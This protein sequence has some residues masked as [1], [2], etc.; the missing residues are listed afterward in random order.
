MEKQR[1]VW[2]NLGYALAATPMVYAGG[3]V[4]ST[5][6]GALDDAIFKLQYGGY[7]WVVLIGAY[8]ISFIYFSY[9]EEIRIKRKRKNTIS[10]MILYW[11]EQLAKKGKAPPLTSEINY[12]SEMFMERIIESGMFDA[13]IWEINYPNGK[14][15]D[16]IFDIV[17]NFMVFY[18]AQKKKGGVV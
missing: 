17:N 2:K 12:A 4:I 15:S 3:L 11:K 16:Y 10:A 7:W 6:V 9:E 18:E 14:Y 1:S 13:E 5:L 8:V